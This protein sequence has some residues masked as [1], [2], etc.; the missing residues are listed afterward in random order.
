[1]PRATKQLTVTEINN[2]KSKNKDYKLFDGQGLYLL[3]TKTGSKLWRLKYRINE[4]EKLIALGAYPDVPLATGTKKDDLNNLICDSEGNPI[5]FKG[6]RAIRDEMKM[7]IASGIDPSDQRAKVKKQN[8]IKEQ[9]KEH[10]FKNIALLRLERKA[11]EMSEAHHKRQKNAFENDVFPIIG[12]MYI[13]DITA[14]DVI[15]VV[16]KM[17]ERG[18]ADSARKVYY[19]V[20][21]TFKWAVTNIDSKTGKSF[22]KSNP[23]INIELEEVIGKKGDNNYPTITD[24]KGISELL[25][26]IDKYT[27]DYTTKQALRIMPYVALRPY[28]I[29]YA[30]WKEIDFDNKQWLISGEKMKTGKD[31]IVP[32]TNSVINILKETQKYSGDSQYIFPSSR[33]KKSPMGDTTLVRAIRRMGY[34]KHELVAHSFRAMFSTVANEK[35]DYK[36]KKDIIDFQLAH[37]VGS[38]VSQAYNRAEY[39]EDRE[40]LMQWWAD[41]L[42]EVKTR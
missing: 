11:S 24:D 23:C 38:K 34:T 8:K 25:R 41:Y 22:A 12:D 15:G 31:L 39:L 26:K 40:K 19:S 29:R 33:S 10:T 1:M 13:D 42:D 2:A 32:L 16:T 5:I 4:K 3:V 6:A 18:V 35:W 9:K 28:N 7:L 37:S 36:N 20:S 21:K 30:E 14:L 27:G 17:M